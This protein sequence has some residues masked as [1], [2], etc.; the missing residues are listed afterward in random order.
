M[1]LGD[2]LFQLAF[3]HEQLP[4][5]RIRFQSFLEHERRKGRFGDGLFPG[6]ERLE[7]GAGFHQ[8]RLHPSVL[9]LLFTKKR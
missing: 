1:I 7:A 6:L 5:D 8:L 2:Q 9:S 3:A 4:T